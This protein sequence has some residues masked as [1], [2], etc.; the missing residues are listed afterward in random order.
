M[1]FAVKATQFNDNYS[2]LEQKPITV[3]VHIEKLHTCFVAAE[4]YLTCHPCPQDTVI[5]LNFP[6]CY[7]PACAFNVQMSEIATSSPNLKIGHVP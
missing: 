5:V 4:L 1:D 2:A 7:L 3:Y 6:F